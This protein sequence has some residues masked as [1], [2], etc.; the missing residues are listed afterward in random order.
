MQLTKTERY[1]RELFDAAPPGAVRFSYQLIRVA[2][3]DGRKIYIDRSHLKGDL[4]RI[5]RTNEL[6]MMEKR[7]TTHTKQDATR[8]ALRF[9]RKGITP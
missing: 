4:W 6:A 9:A 1:G 8:A 2:A 7:G 5:R 3:P